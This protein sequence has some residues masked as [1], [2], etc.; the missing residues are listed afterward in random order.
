[1]KYQVVNAATD[2]VVSEHASKGAA[3]SAAR[4]WVKEEVGRECNI[5]E[6]DDSNDERVPANVMIATK[7]IECL[8]SKVPM[9]S[10]ND[11]LEAYTLALRAL[12]NWLKSQ[13]QSEFMSTAKS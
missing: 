12:S 4:A 1:M 11:E 5:C 8:S 2:N 6:Y 10:S 13:M 3:E 7:V 9:Q